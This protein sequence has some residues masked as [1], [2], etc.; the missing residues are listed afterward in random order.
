MSHIDSHLASP[1]ASPSVLPGSHLAAIANDD[2]AF[3]LEWAIYHRMIGFQRITV[4]GDG[5]SPQ[6]AQLG[7]AMAEIGLIQFRDG[8]ASPDGPRG[9]AMNI[10]LA[11]LQDLARADGTEWLMPMAIEEFLLIEA[12]DGSL[13]ALLQA[14]PG[15]PD[16]ISATWQIFGNSGHGVFE[17]GLVTRRFTR[18]AQTVPGRM[19]GPLGV[20]TLFRPEIAEAIGR[21]RP[22]LARP[23]VNWLNCA[24]QD[25]TDYFRD[26]RWFCLADRPGFGHA[27]I[28][29][30][31]TRDNASWLIRAMSPSQR[32][33]GL[34]PADFRTLLGQ[35]ARL[36]ANRA[37]ENAML[38]WADRIEAEMSRLM[39]AHPALQAAHRAA[40]DDLSARIATFAGELE[41]NAR[42]AVDLFLSNRPI[43]GELLDWEVAP[44]NN[45]RSDGGKWQKLADTRKGEVAE[46]EMFAD[47]DERP[48]F[49]AD[50]PDLVIRAPA[51]L[52]DLRLSDHGHGFY[53]SIPGNALTHVHRSDDLLVVSFDN[54]SSVRDNP[55]DRDP[56]GYEFVRK[57][58]WSQLGVMG[59]AG[60]WYRNGALFDELT[61]LRDEGL[62]T[63]YR[64]VVM[65]G[66]SMG[67]F[68]ACAFAPLA[69]GCTVIAFSPQETLDPK[70]VPWETRFNSGRK[71]S[72]EGR[73]ASAS[74][75][76]AAAERGWLFYDS[77]FA[78][79]L[80]HARRFGG[81]NVEHIEMRLSGHKTAMI[82]RAGGV[83]SRVTRGIIEGSLTRQ[84]FP[85]L[86]QP[87]RKV[88]AYLSGVAERLSDAG[89]TR[90]LKQ[91]VK[92]IEDAGMTRLAKG[93]RRKHL[94]EARKAG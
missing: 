89:R 56:W 17:P 68:A 37:P 43:P 58:G 46:E 60:D 42:Q 39:V 24:G 71:V 3:L 47:Q 7:Q 78:P 67:A 6:A 61:R 22:T 13:P 81:V 80:Q 92:G 51:W 59:Y 86:Y 44:R 63:R 64:R 29:H 11:D 82:L 90:L 25:V 52:A 9:Q 12:G 73:F 77:C 28:A 1:V 49:D 27:R 23:D 53:R 15:K 85:A 30:Y 74:Q 57:S 36:N 14:L 75:G 69:P 16:L 79:D 20:K 87:C 33:R 21:H 45:R 93:L 34:T 48:E 76:L 66:T 88:P 4:Y 38:P 40:A 5:V 18:A 84:D 91:Y 50:A 70:L 94:Q 8:V 62:F 19:V 65:M 26:A 35:H 41:G 31:A 83:L 72:W 55:V 10:C 32:A 54:L 2:A